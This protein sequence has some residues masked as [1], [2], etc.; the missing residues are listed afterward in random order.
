MLG[1]FADDSDHSLAPYYLAFLA[2]NLNTGTHFHSYSTS[3]VPVSYAAP[4]QIIRR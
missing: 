3:L 4:V 1:I 2:S